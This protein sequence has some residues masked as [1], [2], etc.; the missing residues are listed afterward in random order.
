MWSLGFARGKPTVKIE[1][2]DT[3]QQNLMEIRGEFR[4]ELNKHRQLQLDSVKTTCPWHKEGSVGHIGNFGR[5]HEC[6]DCVEEIKAGKCE[7]NVKNFKLKDY[8][9]VK[10]FWEKVDIKGPNDCWLWRGATRKNETETIAYFPS[11]FHST[12]SQSAARVAFWVTRGYTGK[13]RIAHREGCPALCCNPSH[14]KVFGIKPEPPNTK[15]TTIDLS[16]GN[17]FQAHS[18]AL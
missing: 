5:M 7:L 11:P 12:K 15:I 9:I 17:I 14:L 8:W 10:A 18:K 2:P 3:F 4:E 1:S 13:L 6:L 16:Y